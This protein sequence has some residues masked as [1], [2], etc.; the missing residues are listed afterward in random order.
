MRR[1][2]P[3]FLIATAVVFAQVR[4][5]HFRRAAEPREGAFTLL[6]P[7]DW[8]LTGGIQR[9]N[10]L[11]SGGALNA[12]AAKLDLDLASPDGKIR[13]H[14]YPENTFVDVR[15]MPAAPMFPPGSN[16]NGATVL[17]AQNAFGYLEQG[18]RHVHPRATGFRVKNR[19]PV[20][21]AV[22]SYQ[23][24][25]Q[26][27][28]LPMAVRFDAGL[29]V[30]EH[31]ESGVQWEEALYTAVQD[32]GEAGAGLWSNKDTFGARAPAG[33]LEKTGRIVS[34][35]LNS[36][37]LN[38]RWLQGEIRGQMQRN[39][40]AIRTQQE[41]ARLDNEITA[42]RRRTNAEINNMMYHNLMGT[43]EYVN[44]ITKKVEVGA[45]AWNHRWVNEHGE[46]IISDDPNYDPARSGLTG[47]QRSPVRKRFPDK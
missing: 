7:A 27:M 28:R 18:F 24:M 17:P 39:E 11:T 9:V 3:L 22:P 33:E 13:L 25:V 12:V 8:R 31:Q 14:W 20:P 36:V 29:M 37:Q 46:A 23:Q 26:A 45:N 40:I 32:F 15:R 30:V 5:I 2:I 43:E 47:F 10:P 44:P 6:I 21:S 19:Y 1:M 34:I 35:I 41:I 16:Y 4:T 42:N 38:P